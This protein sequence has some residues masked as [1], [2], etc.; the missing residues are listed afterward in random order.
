LVFHG[1]CLVEKTL[2]R[3]SLRVEEELLCPQCTLDA[4]G[5]D[6][7]ANAETELETKS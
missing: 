1:R 4:L 3:R 2:P 5:M 7:D 6:E